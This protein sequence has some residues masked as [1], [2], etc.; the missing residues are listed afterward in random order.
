MDH[1]AETSQEA[2][3]FNSEQYKLRVDRART[4]FLA[5]ADCDPSDAAIILSDA[6][7]EL[8]VGAPIP[9]LLSAMSEATTWAEWAT[10]FEHKAYC[11]ASYNAMQPRDQ[12]AFLGHVQGR[13]A[14]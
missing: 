7:E 2:S 1:G 14:A 8:L 9:P 13:A 6:L 5:I 4:L 11:L 12:A 3:N 10:P